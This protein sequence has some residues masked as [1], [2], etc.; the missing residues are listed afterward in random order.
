MV[1]TPQRDGDESRRHG[2]RDGAY[3]YRSPATRA[4]KRWY[5]WF[6]PPKVADSAS[7]EMRRQAMRGRLATLLLPSM[8]VL[9]LIALP[10]VRIDPAALY[11]ICGT[12]VSIVAAMWLNRRGHVTAAGVVAIL[13]FELIVGFAFM[14][15]TS[16]GAA[17][18]LFVL[19]TLPELLAVGLLP[20]RAVFWVAFL[21]SALLFVHLVA[22][23]TQF[24]GLP[25]DAFVRYG[26]LVRCLFIQWMVAIA[27][28]LMI[29]TLTNVA[30]RLD[31]TEELARMRQADADRRRE[32]ESGTHLLLEAHVAVA[33]GDFEARVQP[34]HD[35][36]LWKLGNSFNML[37][38][39]IGKLDR[40]HSHAEFLLG[41]TAADAHRLAAAINDVHMG[42]MPVWP[43]PSGTPVD[44]VL[45]AMRAMCTPQVISAV[46]TADKRSGVSR[47]GAADAAGPCLPVAPRPF[48]A[49]SDWRIPAQTQPVWQTAETFDHD[50]E[51]LTDRTGET[52]DG[53][54][55]PP[56]G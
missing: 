30:R 29:T 9:A 49:C 33:N 28:Y 48:P 1:T 45:I 51:P 43:A 52:C 18:S 54:S 5:T 12:I 31:R 50:S 17:L 38:A 34:L 10:V 27:T 32:L 11:R 14:T 41:R 24:T 46:H 2:I 16:A 40:A 8:I 22:I 6:A 19:L 13:S 47:P 55:L 36:T 25:I 53:L 39:R 42:R 4:L 37:A 44:E 23:Q 3:R 20:Q 26:I 15:S 35:P 56:L 7:F 21:N